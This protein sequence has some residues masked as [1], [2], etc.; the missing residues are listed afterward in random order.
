[1]SSLTILSIIPL[2]IIHKLGHFPAVSE[3]INSVALIH[4]N[5]VIAVLLRRAR[6]L[7]SQRS[8]FETTS[9][10]LSA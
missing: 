6:R 4:K 1:M 10:H 7:A 8:L 5:E 2:D 9:K 3:E